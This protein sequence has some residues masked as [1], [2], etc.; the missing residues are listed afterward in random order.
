M[1]EDA[2]TL[3]KV[4]MEK[5][6]VKLEAENPAYPPIYTQSARILGKLTYIVRTYS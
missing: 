3:K 1:V 6:R 4:Y 5:N 2:V